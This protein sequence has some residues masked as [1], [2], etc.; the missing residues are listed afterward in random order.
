MAPP[1][2]RGLLAWIAGFVLLWPGANSI[3]EI[4]R[5]FA[6]PTPAPRLDM[7]RSSE[8][9]RI[10]LALGKDHRVFEVLR[11]DVPPDGTV[12]VAGLE[13]DRTDPLPA[14]WWIRVLLYPKGLFLERE[15]ISRRRREVP[16]PFAL[17]DRHFVLEPSPGALP[18]LG[19]RLRIVRREDRFTLWRFVSPP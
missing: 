4:A 17:D 19:G 8:E 3:L 7:L 6:A 1:R 9:E 2:A 11:E 14:Y 10:R 5:R 15:Y 16:D 18:P 12:L 13:P